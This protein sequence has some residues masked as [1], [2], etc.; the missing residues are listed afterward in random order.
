[1][2]H[3]IYKGTVNTESSSNGQLTFAEVQRF[4]SLCF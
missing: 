2:E 3:I 1:M 4:V